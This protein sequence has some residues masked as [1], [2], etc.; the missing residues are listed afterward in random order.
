MGPSAIGEVFVRRHDA[1]GRGG[2]ASHD[3]GPRLDCRRPT[4]VTCA[5]LVGVEFGRQ[6]L[7]DLKRAVEEVCAEQHYVLSDMFMMKIL[8][9]YQV[10]YLQHGL[11]LVGPSGSGKSAAWKVLKE[12]LQRL[13]KKEVF[14][15]VIDPKA[16]TKDEWAARAIRMAKVFQAELG[17]ESALEEIFMW[18]E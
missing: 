3:E 16:I 10:S 9:V 8:Q 17:V 11:M 18:V 4:E 2:E 14:A 15:H 12:A 5:E 7:D 13:E 6:G 1:V